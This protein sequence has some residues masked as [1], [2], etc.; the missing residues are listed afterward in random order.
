MRWSAG[1]LL[2]A[3]WL[4]PCSPAVAADGVPPSSYFDSSGR[5]DVLSGGVKMIT[6]QTPR[7]PFHV[8]TKRVGNNP[9]IKVLLLHGGPGMT[10]EYFEAFDSYLP[11]RES[12]TTTTINWDPHTATSRTSRACGSCRASWRRWNRFAR[13]SSSTRATFTSR[14]IMGW[15]ARARVRAQIPAESEGADHFQH[16]SEHPRLQP[17]C[18]RMCSCPRWIRRRLRRSRLWRWRASMTIPITKS[19]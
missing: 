6:I 13:H 12:S 14:P 7:G 2:F 19:C 11:R 5:D 17:L 16:G 18:E 9:R 8:W 10:H 3:W 4:L 15:H 1:P